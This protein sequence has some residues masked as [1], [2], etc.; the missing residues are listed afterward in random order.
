MLKTLLST[1]TH[2]FLTTHNQ[3]IASDASLQKKRS[4]LKMIKVEYVQLL[5]SMIIENE[6]LVFHHFLM[7]HWH[8]SMIIE[9]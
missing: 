8:F 2:F 3:T 4:S 9:K 7:I 6:Q 1:N 5:K